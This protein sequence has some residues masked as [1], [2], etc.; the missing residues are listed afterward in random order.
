MISQAAADRLMRDLERCCDS[1]VSTREGFDVE[2][3][4][5]NLFE[6]SVRLHSFETEALLEGLLLFADATAQD[7]VITLRIHFPATYPAAPPFIR[8][9]SPRF[10]A[11]TAH[12]VNGAICV[13]DLT[14][15][16]WSPK[17]DILQIIVMVRDLFVAGG[18]LVSLDNLEP[19]SKEEALASF[20]RVAKQHG[21]IA[22]SSDVQESANES[23]EQD[24]EEGEEEEKKEDDDED[25][26]DE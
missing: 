24:H 4:G 17:N 1:T 16:G 13:I 11:Y 3:V 9:I 23:V 25:D 19:Y 18:A 2:T 8:V 20:M 12:V 21:W 26:E 22:V 10:H 15:S 5:S 6:W 7:A 14:M